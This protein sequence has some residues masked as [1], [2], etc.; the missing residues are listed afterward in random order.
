MNYKMMGR[1][2]AQ[3][4]LIGAVF[5]LPALAISLYYGEQ[6]AVYGFALTLGIFAAVIAVLKAVTL[7]VPSLLRIPVLNILES[8]VHPEIKN[9]RTLTASTGTPISAWAAGHADPIKESGTP[10]PMNAM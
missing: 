6:E 8:T 4:L 9:V 2:I 1:F 10:R 5:M 7:A 3:I